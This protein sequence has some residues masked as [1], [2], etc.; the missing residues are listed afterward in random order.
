M[1]DG[2]DGAAARVLV[3][4]MRPFTGFP[5]EQVRGWQMKTRHA[6]ES[7]Q[8]FVCELRASPSLSESWNPFDRL[9][10]GFRILSLT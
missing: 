6:S 3:N 1:A 10:G 8:H 9:Q 4:L 2:G 5:P 7:W